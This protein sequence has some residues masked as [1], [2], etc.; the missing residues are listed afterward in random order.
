MVSSRLGPGFWSVRDERPQPDAYVTDPQRVQ[1]GYARTSML[2]ITLL[3]AQK[4]ADL[5]TTGA[6]I[7]AAVTALAT[8]NGVVVPILPASQ[9]YVSFSPVRWRSY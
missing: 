3:A 4:L 2:P 8:D 9:V 5:L 1:R 7:E 6:A